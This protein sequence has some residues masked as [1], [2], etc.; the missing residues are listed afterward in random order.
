MASTV[1][2]AVFPAAG[3]GTRFLPATKSVPKEML[4]VVDR[5]LI[6]YAVDEARAAGIDDLVVVTGRRGQAIENYFDPDIELGE[7]LAAKGKREE[8]AAMERDLPGPG[9]VA[10]VRQEEPLGLGHAV[11]CARHFVGKDAFAVLL[12]DDLIVAEPG[13]ISQMMAAHTNIGGIVV[14]AMEVAREDTARYGIIDPGA[15]ND[16]IIEVRGL[17]EKPEPENAPSTLAVV[18]RYI[19]VPEVFDHL[20]QGAIGAGGEIQLTDALATMI[21]SM[22]V[23]AFRFAGRRYD[24]GDKAGFI[25]ATVALALARED[26]RDP[27]AAALRAALETSSDA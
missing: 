7:R 3:M 14:A 5:P 20:A 21:G 4:P 15:E 18:G 26:L 23:H 2:K 16:G 17:I 12:A 25:E 1:R 22:P 8:I 9:R 11:W 19:M 13:C 24:C 27:V 10:Y 6:Q